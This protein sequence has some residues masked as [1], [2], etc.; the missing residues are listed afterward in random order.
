VVPFSFEKAN[1]E[2]NAFRAATGGARCIAGGTTLIDLMRE[3]IERSTRLDINISTLLEQ[4]LLKILSCLPR[5]S[6]FCLR[7]CRRDLR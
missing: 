1:S 4:F 5:L 6:R 7:H 3:E 2:S